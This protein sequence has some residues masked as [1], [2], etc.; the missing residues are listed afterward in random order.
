MKPSGDPPVLRACLPCCL[1]ASRWSLELQAP[2]VAKREEE[3]SS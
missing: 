1:E 2:E 3:M